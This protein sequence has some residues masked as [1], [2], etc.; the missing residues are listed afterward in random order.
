[1]PDEEDKQAAVPVG[2]LD[3]YDNDTPVIY[4]ND[5]AL[6]AGNEDA[7]IISQSGQGYEAVKAQVVLRK[8]TPKEQ[9]VSGVAANVSQELTSEEQWHE[10]FEANEDAL[11]AMALSALDRKR[12]GLGMPLDLAVD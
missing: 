7:G 2:R 10:T 3:L 6:P 12:K 5:M 1:M 4:A 9:T 8:P 11:V